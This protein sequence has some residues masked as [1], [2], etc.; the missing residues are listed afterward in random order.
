MFLQCVS[1]GLSWLLHHLIA[2]G[3]AV[4]SQLHE[5]LPVLTSRV[6]DQSC[7]SFP[8]TQASFP[9]CPSTRPPIVGSFASIREDADGAVIPEPHVGVVKQVLN[10]GSVGPVT[11]DGFDPFTFAVWLPSAT[12]VFNIDPHL[13]VN[14]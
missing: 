7:F 14:S 12:F 9:L 3:L 13:S 10:K 5:D 4:E 6:S 2:S 1:S 8:P 11:G